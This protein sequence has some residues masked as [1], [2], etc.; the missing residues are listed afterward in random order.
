M[1]LLSC[2]N[3]IPIELPGYKDLTVRCRK[4]KGCLLQRQFEW[5]N[6]MLLENW[7]R[8][9]TPLFMTWTFK[10]S[11]YYDN[12]HYVFTESQK[13]YRRIRKLGHDLRYFSTIERGKK[14]GRLHIHSILWSESLRKLSWTDQFFTLLNTWGKGAIK[15]RV[16]RSPGAFH[17]VAKYL[18]KDLLKNVDYTTGEF[19]SRRPY[20]YSNRPV[21]GYKGIQRWKELSDKMFHVEH[22]PPNWFNMPFMG[23]LEKAYIPSDDWKRYVKSKIRD[24]T[25]EEIIDL[26]QFY[27]PE[28]EVMFEPDQPVITWINDKYQVIE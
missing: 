11:Y 7:G 22:L 10:P 8:T 25:V 12:R 15:M 5:K 28:Q 3:R 21:I 17:Y 18:V 14:R 24:I 23:K 27:V 16:V 9:D 2:E 13:L 1:S 6:R 19:S 26:D 4:C 20:T